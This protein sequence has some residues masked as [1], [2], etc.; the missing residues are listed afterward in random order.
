MM[1][2]EWYILKL[3]KDWH[4]RKKR[5]GLYVWELHVDITRL[6]LQVYTLN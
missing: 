3:L 2:G 4:D 1:Y 5:K 6:S